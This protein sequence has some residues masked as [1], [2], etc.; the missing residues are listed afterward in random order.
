MS[1]TLTFDCSVDLHDPFVRDY[2]RTQGRTPSYGRLLKSGY[3]TCDGSM[4]STRVFLRL[5]EFRRDGTV[6][7]GSVG[8]A[9]LPYTKLTVHGRSTC[10]GNYILVPSVLRSVFLVD[11]RPV[12][13]IET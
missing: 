8:R 3:T 10:R 9:G 1:V 7:S 13:K 5:Y 11:L 2:S 4:F 12:S 6:L